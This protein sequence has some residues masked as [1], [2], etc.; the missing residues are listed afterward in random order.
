MGNLGVNVNENYMYKSVI[1]IPHV[2]KVVSSFLK[3]YRE[4]YAD[5]L[6]NGPQVIIGIDSL[7]MLSTEQELEHFEKGDNS[8]DQGLRAKQLKQM[9]RQFVQAIKDLNVAMVVTGQVYRAKQ[10]QILQGEGVWIVNEAIR[11]AL[12]QITLLKKL[13]LKDKEKEILG[14]RMIAEGFKTRFTKPFQTVE[15]E[16]PYDTGIDPLSGLKDCLV[17]LGVLEKAGN[18]WQLVGTDDPF[19]EKDIADH[20]E[21]LLVKAEAMSNEYVKAGAT[22]AEVDT[23]VDSA[24]DM[25]AKRKKA[26]SKK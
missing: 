19:F 23:D 22:D 12:S 7:D 8:S 17:G 2:I 13:K 18:R 25:K 24:E 3:G 10:E 20:A 11:Y 5:D 6:L 16:V 21:N 9:L 26:A 4:E 14:F 15:V 1:T